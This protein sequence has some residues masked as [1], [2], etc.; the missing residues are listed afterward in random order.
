MFEKKTYS[1]T[2]DNTT[3]NA[4]FSNIA[5]KA[6]GSV[7][8]EA[9]GTLVLVTA[10]MSPNESDKDYFP[11]SVEYEEKFYAAGVILGSS[12]LRR[13]GRPSKTATINARIIDRTIR[14]LFPKGFKREVQVVVTVLSL[15]NQSP[16]TLGILGAS[17][18][19]GISDIP[20]NG[21]VSCALLNHTNNQWSVFT[22]RKKLS[23]ADNKLI[24]CGGSSGIVMIEMEGNQKKESDILDGCLKA[25]D[26]IEKFQ[27]FQHSIL[28]ENNITKIPWTKPT[29][30]QEAESYFEKEIQPNLHSAIFSKKEDLTDLRNKWKKH[31][32]GEMFSDGD[33][34]L[35]DDYYDDQIDAIV[36]TEAIE[37]K[38]RQD[39]RTLDEIRPLFAQAGGFSEHIHGTGLFYRGD[40]HVFTALTLAGPGE[41]I[42]VSEIESPDR[43]DYFM[44]HYN[45]P[46]FSTGEAGKM[47][48]PKR[49]EIGHGVLAEKA[50]RY[51]IPNQ[52]TFPYTIRLVSEC[53]S[54]S[55]STSMASVC[56]STLA[57]MDG[58]VP[59]KTPVAGIAIGLMTKG[60][61]YAILTD[62]QGFEDH[63]GDMD[64]KIAGTKNGIT[65]MQLDVKI[66]G[67][68]TNMLSEIFE[69]G[70]IAREHILQTITKEIETPRNKISQH[71]PLIQ[72][73]QISTDKIGL[74]IGSGGKTI[75]DIKESS[76]A[77]D[78]DIQ[79]DGTVNISGTKDAVADAVNKIE[80]LTKEVEVGEELDVVIRGIKDFGAFAEITPEQDGL[81]HISEFSPQRID[82]VESVVSVGDTVPVVVKEVDG[83][84]IRLSIKDRDPD[85]FA[86]SLKTQN[87]IEHKNDR[88][89]IKRVRRQ[90]Q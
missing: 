88:K 20:F 61:K 51:V 70:K 35:A 53:L 28:K 42:S 78:I 75:R 82:T 66:G 11:L 46:P 79:D 44:H 16:E 26:I 31:L 12:Y 84:R 62:I 15:G 25:N 74:V 47:G 7:M 58:G 9:D 56:A 60:G 37:N 73:I 72:T 43:S 80:M 21:P 38:R 32:E 13:E 5:G 30:S 90:K 39:G 87:H 6:N 55:G 77:S 65:A 29:L 89:Q 2:I 3:F 54:S 23:D 52:T 22:E 50:L 18:A 41:A 45:F 67:V 59:I 24:V 1:T 76:G 68:Q 57:L 19:L 4:H 63:Y 14:P 64:F 27:E 10:T 34:A 8:V 36:H 69:K 33:R 48:G 71:A 85:F 83:D 49:R 40:T 81:I 86:S 17:L